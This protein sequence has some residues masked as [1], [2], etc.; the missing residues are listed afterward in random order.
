GQSSRNQKASG[1]V[2]YLIFVQFFHLRN[3][4]SYTCVDPS[5]TSTDVILL[6]TLLR[7]N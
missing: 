1:F 6:V 4:K 7:L 3:G 5:V 2:W